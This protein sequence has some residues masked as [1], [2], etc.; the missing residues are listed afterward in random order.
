[1]IA[2]TQERFHALDAARAFALLLGIVLHGTMSFFIPLPAQDISQ[3]TTLGVGFY[4]I[5]IFRMS[6]F[7]F[8]AGFFAHMVFHRRGMRAFVKDRAKRILVP[9]TAGWLVLAVPTI[10][11][12][13]WGLT[14]TFPDG[15][16]PGT[17]VQALQPQ[18]FPLLHLWFLY[19][20]TLFYVLALGLRAGFVALL[21]RSGWL[22]AR[23]DALVGGG[24]ATYLAPIALAIPIFAVLYF[25][26]DWPVWFGVPTPDTGFTPKMPALVGFGTAFAFGWV[27]HRQTPLLGVLEKQW[28]VNLGVAIGLTTACLAIVGVAP[29]TTSLF[30]I[31][32]P[33]EMRLVYTACYTASIWYWTFGIVGAAIRFCSGLSP[34]RRY[35]ADSSYWLYLGH[36]PI[37]FGLQ[38][39]LMKVPLHWTIKFPAIIA[40]TV[41]VLLVS[42]HYLVRPT[43]IGAILNGRKYPRGTHTHPPRE[44]APGA[45][46]PHEPGPRGGPA[47]R[48]ALERTA[49]PRTAERALGSAG[50]AP[51]AALANV[52]KR[53]GKTVALDGVSLSVRPGELLALLGPN[54]AGKT[55]AIGL[56]LGLL[57]P[58][59][60]IVTVMGGS[61]LDVQ[62]RLG[63]GVMLQEVNLAPELRAREHV[64]LA[65]SYYRDPL[66]VEETIALAGI[67][68]LAHKRYGKLSAGQKRQVQF[69]TAIA[70]RPQLLF[71]DEPTVGLDVEARATMWRN[72]RRLLADGCSI[73]LTTHYLEEAE[74]LADRVAVIAKGRLIAEGTVDEMRSLVSRKRISCASAIQ[75]EDI[76][77]WPGVVE[78]VRDDGTV[79]VTAFDAESVVRKLLDADAALKNL[80]VKQATL[81]EAFTE[82]TKEAA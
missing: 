56:W 34:A 43:F 72:I 60:G 74:A 21:D 50:L 80:E 10:G 25:K 46:P 28:L 51:V 58:N 53:Y 8:I 77:R 5:H 75:V 15:P 19:Y 42:Y 55:T 67:E 81:A 30:I 52:T 40:I 65:G 37:V 35:L 69:A 71:L 63:V 2:H 26:A 61:P 13:V 45:P 36:L 73:V 29:N 48:P 76:K 68:P 38:V 49:P 17:D 79:H 6:L 62:S 22:R 7:Y 32:G 20:L 41:A 3:S 31:D 27:L 4:V 70:G 23:I 66:P 78:A 14:R 24:L 33:A 57:E 59:D 12:V 1:M 18:G 47:P 11:A 9:M 82:L 44:P 16:P 39:L 54:G 64:E